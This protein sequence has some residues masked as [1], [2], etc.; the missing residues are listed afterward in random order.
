MYPL[1]PVTRWIYIYPFGSLTTKQPTDNEQSGYMRLV[2]LDGRRSRPI[3][4]W[5]LYECL[6]CLSFFNVNCRI[7]D[8]SWTGYHRSYQKT[9]SLS[10]SE[11]LLQSHGTGASPNRFAFHLKISGYIHRYNE[12]EMRVG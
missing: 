9:I 7:V 6:K 3:D 4:H 12:A 11:H 5:P 10:R 2:E 8:I 1:F